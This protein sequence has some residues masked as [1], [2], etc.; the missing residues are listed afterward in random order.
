[1]KN[2]LICSAPRGM[3]KKYCSKKC[4]KRAWYIRN[5]PIGKKSS[6]I[7]GSGFENTETG[8]GLKWEKYVANLLKAEHT[9]FNT[10]GADLNWNGKLIDVK[11]CNLWFRDKSDKSGVWVFNRNKPKPID[12]FFCVCLIKNVPVKMLLI[13][14]S[15][16]PKKGIVIGKNSK[17][18]IYKY[19]PKAL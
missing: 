5:L 2:C 3:R 18:D 8:I 19:V 4:I 12:F 6:F 13:P 17:Y 15:I 10:L 1:M 14:S 7:D 11:S 9:P 16:F